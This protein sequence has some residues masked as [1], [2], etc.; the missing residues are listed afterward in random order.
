MSHTYLAVLFTLP[1]Q[2]LSD[3]PRSVFRSSLSV[4]NK[5]EELTVGRANSYSRGDCDFLS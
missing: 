1:Y 4:N 2:F 5:T 3:K